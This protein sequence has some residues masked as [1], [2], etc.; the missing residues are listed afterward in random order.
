MKS[1]GVIALAAFAIV[2]NAVAF[3]PLTVTQVNL[4]RQIMAT[5]ENDMYNSTSKS[6]E[7]IYSYCADIG[8]GQG[9]TIGFT[10]F[11]TNGGDA[12]N[13]LNRYNAISP[14]NV[15]A[16][17]NGLFS[18]LKK[19]VN[20]GNVSCL[21]CKDSS[22]HSSL[23]CNAVKKAY[24]NDQANY[25][26]AQQAEDDADNW[27]HSDYLS[28]KYNILLP[29]SQAFVYDSCVNHACDYVGNDVEGY[30]IKRALNGRTRIGSSNSTQQAFF[31]AMLTTRKNYMCSS[32]CDCCS[33]SKWRIP[34]WQWLGEQGYWFL[35]NP[36][37]I[38]NFQDGSSARAIVFQCDSEEGSGCSSEPDMI[39][40]PRSTKHKAKKHKKKKH[41]KHH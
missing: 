9:V 11:T 4:A 13:M 24:A 1:L 5:W 34:G 40:G 33:D 15:F 21:K 28:K 17:T 6:W 8:D 25:I 26:L 29:L 23:L 7:L 3:T 38:K 30:I 31:K 41:H 37:K 18:C 14:G 39:A 12:L 2:Q 32:G 16:K 22:C 19:I 27:H 10:G 35:P 20:T 36:M